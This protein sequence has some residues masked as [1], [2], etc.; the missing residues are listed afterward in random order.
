MN[1]RF[2]NHRVFQ[3][4]AAP[5]AVLVVLA[6]IAHGALAQERT[7]DIAAFFGQ[8]SGTG[9]SESAISLYF[10]LTTRDLDVEVRAAGAGFELSWTTVQRQ[11]GDP[12]NPTPVRKATVIRFAPSG[13]PNVWRAVDSSDP[14]L[15]ERYAW[16]RIKGQTL[17]VH[18]LVI[19]E[20]GG[21]DMQVYD[22]T[23]TPFGMELEFVAFRDGEERRNASGRLVKVGN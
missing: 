2:K 16:A 15:D 11:S 4:V 10:R 5:V 12:T 14:L 22:R 8:W 18:T 17:T 7:V 1:H 9:V 23:L 19:G 6:G 13:R 21:Y 3:A 20:D